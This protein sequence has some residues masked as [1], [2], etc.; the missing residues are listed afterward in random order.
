MPVAK[1]K[2]ALVRR[3]VAEWVNDT[4][5]CF[6]AA[7]MIVDYFGTRVEVRRFRQNLRAAKAHLD[8]IVPSFDDPSRPRLPMDHPPPFKCGEH[9]ASMLAPI[10]QLL[11]E[12]VPAFLTSAKESLRAGAYASFKGH[13]CGF[14]AMLSYGLCDPIWA[15]FPRLAPQGWLDCQR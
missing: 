8:A 14:V 4:A 12:P 2:N 3:Q 5:S 13:Y 11:V 6:R 7:E 10:L 15:Q 9:L 1:A